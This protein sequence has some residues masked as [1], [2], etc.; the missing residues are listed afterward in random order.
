MN[1]IL[2]RIISVVVVTISFGGCR[3]K[4]P[5]GHYEGTLVEQKNGQSLN[6]AVG[7]DISLEKVRWGHFHRFGKIRISDEQ[8]SVISTFEFS[9]SDKKRVTLRIPDLREEP[10]QL[11]VA[12]PASADKEIT[13]YQDQGIWDAEFCFDSIEFRLRVLNPDKANVLKL[14][15]NTFVKEPAFLLETPVKLSVQEVVQ[16]AFESNIEARISFEH[17]IQAK[18]NVTAAYLNLIPHLTS[19]LI[20]NAQPGFISVIATLQGI[21]PFLLPNYWLQARESQ[22]DLKIKKDS[23]IIQKAD[24]AAMV[25]QISYAYARDQKISQIQEFVIQGVFQLEGKLRKMEEAGQ[26]SGGSAA[27][28]KVLLETLESDY[29]KTVHLVRDEQYALSQALGY[30]NPEAISAISSLEGL[31][32]QVLD[33]IK[34]EEFAQSVS[35]RSFEL[36]QIDFLREIAKLKKTELFFTWL[37]PQGDPKTGLGFNTIPQLKVSSSQI[38]ELELKR[39]QLKIAV[40]QNAYRIA[41]EYNETIQ[42]FNDV[43]T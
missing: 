3:H 35:Q 31:P 5:L 7:I 22:W 12:A 26:V 38:H 10:F 29:D 8:G 40:Y 9:T 23:Q 27:S 20:W 28:L 24:S 17:L 37:D 19:N 4:L 6:Q 1:K 42:Y 14:F 16:R 34:N 33:P 43:K 2:I 41:N 18:N 25:E 15:G 36:Q 11:K 39:E 13:C 32:T 30:H 21:A